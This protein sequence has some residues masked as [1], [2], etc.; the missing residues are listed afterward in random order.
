[1]SARIRSASLLRLVSLGVTLALVVPPIPVSGVSRPGPASTPLYA[2][3][4]RVPAFSHIYV[5]VM[6]NH[7][8][9]SIVGSAKAP[10]T[11]A[12]IRRYGLATNYTA[13]SHPSEPNYLALWAGSTFGIHDDA[14][15]N[16]AARNLADQLAAHR[17]T[18]HVYAQDLPRVCSTVG[19][20]SG[21]VDLIGASGEYVR[22]H[23]PAISFTDIARSRTRCA[24]IT[25]LATFRP[26]AANFEL[27]V[28]NMTNDMHDG[29][30]AQGDAFLRAFVPRIT[31]SAA[32]ANSLLVITW[33]EGSTSVGGGGRVATIL[34]SPRSFAGHRSAIA[35]NHY[36]LLRTI[37]NAWG[38][39]CLNQT[40]RANDLREFFR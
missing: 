40:C 3:A 8:Y 25:R 23:E 7:E 5:I 31:R 39:G 22:K 35:H 19:S 20:A 14:I 16:L 28:P 24:Q 9:G 26:A 34:I 37:E 11:N 13:V 10:Y 36:S 38:L 4:L 6:E 17:K 18:W 30:I 12:L 29:S 21:G 15:H 2:T 27:I 1:M 32:F 33:D